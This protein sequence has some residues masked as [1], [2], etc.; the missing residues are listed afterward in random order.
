MGRVSYCFSHCQSSQHYIFLGYVGLRY[1]LEHDQMEFF[2]E[3][4]S[5]CKYKCL[6]L[7][8][9]A[10]LL[11]LDLKPFNK[12]LQVTYNSTIIQSSLLPIKENISC[13]DNIS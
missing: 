8:N 7:S 2:L 12:D 1:Q 10:L 13:H 6:N 9:L 3:Y 5:K 11:L 4:G